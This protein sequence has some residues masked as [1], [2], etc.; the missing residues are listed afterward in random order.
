M[1]HDRG[2]VGKK[3]ERGAKRCEDGAEVRRGEGEDQ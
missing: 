2:E 3:G 1:N